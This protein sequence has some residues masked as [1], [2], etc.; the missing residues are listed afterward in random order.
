MSPKEEQDEEEGAEQNGHHLNGDEIG[1]K[2][3]GITG[4][5]LFLGN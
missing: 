3:E 4:S 5:H 2:K 1:E